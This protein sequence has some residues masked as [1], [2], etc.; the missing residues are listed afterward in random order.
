MTAGN[1]V[2]VAE[3]LQEPFLARL[4]EVGDVVYDPD[5]YDDRSRLLDAVSGANAIFIRNRTQI[6]EELF[7]AAQHLRVVGR[8]GVGMDNI[9][10]EACARANVEIVP[11]FGANAVSVA[12]YVLAALLVLT[13]PV[14][15]KT[16]SMVR[17]EWPRQ[18]HAFGR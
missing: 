10:T 18:G 13:R 6:D 5:L 16:E 1:R 7:S 4:A 2:V 15:D 8:L 17:G 3:Y 11:G 9:D 14:F 12:E